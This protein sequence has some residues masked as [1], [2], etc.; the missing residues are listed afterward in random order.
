MRHNRSRVIASDLPFQGILPWQIFP[1]NAYEMS[2][3]KARSKS[4]RADSERWFKK[5]DEPVQNAGP[6]AIRG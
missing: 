4:I 1:L 2:V 6:F 5:I 3:A